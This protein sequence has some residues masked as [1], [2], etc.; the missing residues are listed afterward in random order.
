MKNDMVNFAARIPKF[1][2]VKMEKTKEETMHSINLQI[3][4]SL[5]KTVLKK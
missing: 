2:Y 5:K 3:V 4:D 1:I